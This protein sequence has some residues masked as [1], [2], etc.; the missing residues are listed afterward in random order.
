[1][2]ERLVSNLGAP[3]FYPPPLFDWERQRWLEHLSPSRADVP[4]FLFSSASMTS[5]VWK[6]TVE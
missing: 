5:S 4:V 6:Q 2:T 3:L 1:M